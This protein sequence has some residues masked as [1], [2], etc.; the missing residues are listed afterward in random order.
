MIILKTGHLC[1]LLQIMLGAHMAHSLITRPPRS[2][3]QLP[4]DPI[5]VSLQ[6]VGPSWP[7]QQ[8]AQNCST[9][10]SYNCCV[11]FY[12]NCEQ[13]PVIWSIL[14]GTHAETLGML[15]L[16]QVGFVYFKFLIEIL[17]CI[18]SLPTA[19]CLY[20]ELMSNVCQCLGKDVCNLDIRHHMWKRECMIIISFPNRVTVHLNTFCLL[21]EDWVCCNKNITC[22]IHLKRSRLSFKKP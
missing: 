6:W 12:E 4:G 3:R 9:W 11:F 8:L 13:P 18:R 21:M 22:I 2:E 20:Q 5:D 7:T 19:I 15:K 16:L 17:L 10:D 14:D 1:L